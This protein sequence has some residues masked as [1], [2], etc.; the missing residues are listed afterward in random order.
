[1]GNLSL[2]KPNSKP[3]ITQGSHRISLQRLQF[4]GGFLI[5]PPGWIGILIS[6]VL[7]EMGK[8]PGTTQSPHFPIF[9]HARLRHIFG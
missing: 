9:N 4:I 5:F 1:M 2:T 3:P 6:L 8:H 7:V